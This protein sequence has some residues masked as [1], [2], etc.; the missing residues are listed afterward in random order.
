MLARFRRLPLLIL[1]S[2]SVFRRNV[3][4]QLFHDCRDNDC[5]KMETARKM[6]KLVGVSGCQY[7]REQVARSL[8]P[9]LPNTVFI[10][11]LVL[12]LCPP[13]L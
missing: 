12:A 11:N 6:K 3:F 7:L 1:G 4:S 5:R 10:T 13:S 9:R 2:T 8:L